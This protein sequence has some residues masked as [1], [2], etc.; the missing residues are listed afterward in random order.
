MT[1]KTGQ[2][3]AAVQ[4]FH[5]MDVISRANARAALMPAGGP[6][7]L[8]MEVGQPASGAPLGARLAA[9]AALRDGT[10]L[11]Y[12]EALGLAALRARIARH[13]AEHYG[14]DLSPGRIAVTTG[15]SAGFSLAFLACLDPGD[16][17]A[18]ATPYYPPYV[19]IL[20]ALGMRPRL[21]ETG[22]DT[23]FQ[24]TPALL[25]A[26]GP[27]PAC[28]LIASPSNPAGTMLD[29]GELDALTLW[30]RSR[31]VRLISDEIYHRLVYEGAEH[32][33]A[34]LPDTITVG[35]MSK[36]WCMTGWRIGW[37]VLPEPLV[38]T[39]E[40]LA[41]NLFISAPHLSQRAAIA[42]FDCDDELCLNVQAYQR[43]RTHLLARFAEAGLDRLAPAQ[44]AFYL[45]ADISALAPDSE[46]FCTRLLEEANIA[47]TP[48]LDFDAARGHRYVRF[49]YCGPE[50]DMHEAADRLVRW[51][52]RGALPRTP[53]GALPLDPTKGSRP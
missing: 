52:R 21:I 28:L 11:G 50:P 38:R 33:A 20:T 24:P 10:A 7:V 45:Y 44:G 16:E 48:G 53:P 26:S 34:A 51:A 37:L 5:A 31:G 6:S 1:L 4:P 41:Q 29:A 14:I 30:C 27:P 47:A 2:A 3:A 8:R 19:N 32:S 42:A 18:L 46:T 43:A 25:D 40:R 17:V 36:Y 49:S 23:R 22:P 35:S 15:A 39:V 13:Y 9:E 12:T